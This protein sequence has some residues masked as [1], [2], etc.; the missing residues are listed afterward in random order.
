MK[1]ARLEDGELHIRDVPIPEPEFEEAL[2]HIS[3][4]GIC[5]S[6]LHIAKSDWYGIGGS[7][8]LG[9]EAIG[10]VE[11]LGPGRRRLRVGGRP[12]DPRSRRRGRRVL[13]RR[14]PRVPQRSPASVR[15][16]Q[17][18]HGHVLGALPRV[19]Q[20]ARRDPRRA[21]RRGGPARVRWSHRVRR[22]EEAVRP[23]RPARPTGRDPRRRRRAGSLRGA[24]RQ[25]V[26]L[27]GGG[28]RRR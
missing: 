16:E 11:A 14:V 24:D 21:R 4:A 12:G 10:I 27:H 9:H 23:P 7:G 26:R 18:D 19:R 6:D 8:V 15:A 28:H 17:A 2:I 25:G 13:V 1:A 20:V 5:H 22:G 3:A